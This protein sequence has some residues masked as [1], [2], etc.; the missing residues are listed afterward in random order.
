M[1]DE[2]FDFWK[3]VFAWTIG[4]AGD[5]NAAAHR[6]GLRFKHGELSYIDENMNL[7]AAQSHSVFEKN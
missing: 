7:S 6:V 1:C 5:S 2:K 4:E 3:L